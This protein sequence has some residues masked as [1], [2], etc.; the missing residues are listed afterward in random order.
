MKASFLIKAKKENVI[1]EKGVRALIMERLLNSAFLKG[2]LLNIDAKTVEVQIE[3][4]EKQIGV[5][6]KELEKQLKN[7]LGNPKILFTETVEKPHLEL[8]NLMRSS[9]AL[10]VG[11]LEKGIRV[12]LDILGEMKRLS[13]GMKK[14]P[15]E[16]A[17]HLKN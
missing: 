1:T 13:G 4:D 10:V 8:P 9:Q 11:Q 2:A 7:L 3:G 12:Q 16:I 15:V 6:K 5:F 17:R 14:L